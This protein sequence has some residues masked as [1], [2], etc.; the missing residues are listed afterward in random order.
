MRRLRLR[1]RTDG[2]QGVV[3]LGGGGNSVPGESTVFVITA[4]SAV[5]AAA[6]AAAAATAT[7]AI[8]TAA[9]STAVRTTGRTAASTA[10]K[11]AQELVL[12]LDAPFT[13]P[14]LQHRPAK[15]EV[16]VREFERHPRTSA[17]IDLNVV[18]QPTRIHI[19]ICSE[20]TYTTNMYRHSI[21][22]ASSDSNI[23]TTCRMFDECYFHRIHP[24]TRIGSYTRP[25]RAKQSRLRLDGRLSRAIETKRRCRAPARKSDDRLIQFR[26]EIV[27]R[28]VKL[29]R[30][31]SNW[32]VGRDVYHWFMNC[33]VLALL[34]NAFLG[35]LFSD[36]IRIVK[37]RYL[38]AGSELQFMTLKNYIYDGVL[39]IMLRKKKLGSIPNRTDRTRSPPEG[40]VRHRRRRRRWDC[41]WVANLTR[42]RFTFECV[43]SRSSFSLSFFPAPCVA[44][45]ALRAL[46]LDTRHRETL[47]VYLV[48]RC[49]CATGVCDTDIRTRAKR[50]FLAATRSIRSSIRENIDELEAR[51]VGSVQSY[52][53]FR[54]IREK[55]FIFL[56]WS[57]LA[58]ATFENF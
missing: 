57:S 4:A 35:N 6:A 16:E 42:V 10:T 22:I 19:L 21:L 56:S 40:A 58:L 2:A 38:F 17:K 26:R 14:Q 24:H 32:K 39:N 8:S 48:K 9:V 50:N 33:G 46:T 52:S 12:V 18:A 25:A 23:R 45:P 53:G 31:L 15:P 27:Q 49:R 44:T 47:R 55:L 37:Y 3:Q 54:D 30:T 13:R 43:L 20:R 5:A 1:H 28:S 34:C 7:A 41:R 29:I 11:L 36:M 51:E